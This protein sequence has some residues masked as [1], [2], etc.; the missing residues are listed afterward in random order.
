MAK[1]G[2]GSRG[3]GLGRGNLKG[4]IGNSDLVD[5]PVEESPIDCDVFADANHDRNDTE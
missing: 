4:I 2:R 1:K 5:P 3:R